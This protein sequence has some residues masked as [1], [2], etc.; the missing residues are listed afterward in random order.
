[1]SPR[2]ERPLIRWTW[3]AFQNPDSSTKMFGDDEPRPR[4]GRFDWRRAAPS[5][6]EIGNIPQQQVKLLRVLEEGELSDPARPVRTGK[7]A[8]SP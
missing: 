1:M 8:L 4:P 7:F 3:P 5:L 6:E 2:A